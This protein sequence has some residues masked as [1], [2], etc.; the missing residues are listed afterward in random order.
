MN[1]D[2][3]RN[4]QNVQKNATEWKTNLEVALQELSEDKRPKLALVVDDDRLVLRSVR[5][6]LEDHGY[7]VMTAST[8]NAA[9]RAVKSVVPKLVVLDIMLPD[10]NGDEVFKFIRNHEASA[11]VPVV[12]MSGT[13]SQNEEQELNSEDLQNEAYMAK[14]FNID[15]LQR[16]ADK[17]LPVLTEPVSTEC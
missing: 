17:L 10:I 1:R 2:I 14:P 11:H 13:I 12:F 4:I 16:L 8:G 15:K 7:A 3:L 9:I 6:L 5:K